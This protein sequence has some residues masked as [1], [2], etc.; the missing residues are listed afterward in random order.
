M[1]RRLILLAGFML[2][3]C[4]AFA[5]GSIT[6][7]D[8][9]TEKPPQPVLHYYDRHGNRLQTPVLFLAEL[10]TVKNVRSGPVY[11][12]VSGMSVGVNFFDAILKLFGQTYSSFDVHADITLFNWL[13]PV[14]EAGVGFASSSPDNGAFHI[15]VH[16]SPYV[17]IGFNYNFLYKSNPDYQFWLG[18]RAG[19]ANSRYDVW[20]ITQSCDY[21]VEGGPTAY[22]GLR[23]TSWYGD[24]LAGLRVRIAGP[25]SLGWSLRYHFNFS[26]ARKGM[27]CPPWFVP[28]YGHNPLGATFSVYFDLYSNR[29]KTPAAGVGE[30]VNTSE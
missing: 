9:D 2:S 22:D 10:D 11:P 7:V 28:G 19:M 15:K 5:Q 8:N 23:C 6:P 4:A 1:K 12:A 26:R 21:Y 20:G 18:L 16:P 24:V 25:V 13:M 17:K 27:A 30:M 29:K 14:V 3:V